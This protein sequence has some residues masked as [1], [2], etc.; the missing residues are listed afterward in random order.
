MSLFI[1]YSILYDLILANSCNENSTL[2]NYH[3]LIKTFSFDTNINKPKITNFYLS[4]DAKIINNS[5]FQ[6]TLNNTNS[7]GSI[8]NKEKFSTSK[9]LFQT[10]ISIHPHNEKS[11][12]FSIWFLIDNNYKELTFD[13]KITGFGIIMFTNFRYQYRTL[14]KLVFANNEKLIDSINKE[15]IKHGNCFD[16]GN[17]NRQIKLDINYDF[18]IGNIFFSYDTPFQIKQM[19]MNFHQSDEKINRMDFLKNKEFQIG[20]FSSNLDNFNDLILTK[21]NVTLEDTVFIYKQRLF[22]RDKNIKE[23]FVYTKEDLIK[24]KKDSIN[25]KENVQFEEKDF[26]NKNEETKDINIFVLIF[27]FCV[28]VTITIIFFRISE[29]EKVN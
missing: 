2:Y 4:N 27:L 21:K 15:K 7:K 23:K 29:K 10:T 9:F 16:Y 1:I 26:K 22:N 19:C 5:L 24:E 8:I 18:D 17:N 11:S 20:F 14:Y 13:T 25:K 28:V 12:F 3:Q 6:L